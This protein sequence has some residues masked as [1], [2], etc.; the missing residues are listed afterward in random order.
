MK[1]REGDGDRIG[2]GEIDRWRQR[3]G[4]ESYFRSKVAVK[5]CT[6]D[7]KESIHPTCYNARCQVL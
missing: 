5:Y 4:S 6:K 7:G 2:G 3:G 1:G